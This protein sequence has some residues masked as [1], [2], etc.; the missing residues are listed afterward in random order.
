MDPAPLRL[1]CAI[2][3]FT[4]SCGG[5][6]AR[7]TFELHYKWDG[8]PPCAQVGISPEFVVL[9]APFTTN[10][11]SFA[12]TGVTGR[13]FGGATVNHPRDGIIESG[14][15]AHRG[16][17]QASS[18]LWTVEALDQHGNVVGTARKTMHFPN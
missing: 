12:L 17:C 9:N 7:D 15:V 11:L 10:K 5:A 8:T 3:A 1:T 2:I 13:S 4:S 6:L 16:P 14:A 18:Y